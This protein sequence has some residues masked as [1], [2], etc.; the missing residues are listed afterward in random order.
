MDTGWIVALVLYILGAAYIAT[1][2]E[3]KPKSIDL[4]VCL[5]V[6]VFWP[7]TAVM[8]VIWRYILIHISTR[9]RSFYQKF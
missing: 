4:W 7:I 3:K 8:V 2:I 5:F 6:A 9:A 1:A